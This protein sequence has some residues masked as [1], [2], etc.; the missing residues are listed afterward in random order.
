[1]ETGGWG[2]GE[3]CYMEPLMETGGWG[4]GEFCYMEP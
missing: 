2:Q 1:M 4:Q 3:F